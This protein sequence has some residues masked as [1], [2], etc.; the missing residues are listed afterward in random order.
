QQ[1]ALTS[2]IEKGKTSEA[3]RK[4][5]GFNDQLV[6]GKYPYNINLYSLDD[7]TLKTYA[8]EVGA[9]YDELQNGLNAIVIDQ[10]KYEDAK[11][12]KYVESKAINTK[13]GEKIDLFSNDEDH[14]KE[15]FLNKVT[16]AA[17]TSKLPMGAYGGYPG[18]VD[19]I[20]SEST[21]KKLGLEAEDYRML[22]LNSSDPL[23]TQQ[24]IEEIEEVRH[25][26]H[27]V[28][29]GRQQDEQMV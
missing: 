8:E 24:K 19:V 11:A 1:Y 7:D 5:E 29:Q 16:V 27:N 23:K 26:L 12:G 2:W 22:Y 10:I 6:D 28:Y 15:Q 21:L 3:V 4:F 9:D 14:E 13:V 20:V 17:L 25:Y 18:S